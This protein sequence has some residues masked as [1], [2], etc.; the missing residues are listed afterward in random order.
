MTDISH[1][2]FDISKN[3]GGISIDQVFAFRQF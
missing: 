1:M 3:R 2:I